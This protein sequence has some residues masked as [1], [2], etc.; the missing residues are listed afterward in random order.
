MREEVQY[1]P[2]VSPGQ[3]DSVL[4]KFEP[5]KRERP[6]QS[7]CNPIDQETS[8]WIAQPTMRYFG[9]VVRMKS[10]RYPKV[11]LQG[12]VHGKR[13]RGRPRKRWIDVAEEDCQEMGLTVGE[14]TRRAQDRDD[15]RLSIKERL[16]RAKASPGP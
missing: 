13:R 1:V 16:M 11:A 15:W 12:Y 3:Q 5:R 7:P 4:A 14:A 9:H 8:I 10:G 2:V 6:D